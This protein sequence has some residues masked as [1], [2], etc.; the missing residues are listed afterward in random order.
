ML[1]TGGEILF[2]LS[3][4]NFKTLSQMKSTNQ[5]I[6][7]NYFVLLISLLS[8]FLSGCGEDPVKENVPELITKVTLTFKP[9]GGGSNVVV[10]A[11]DPDGEGVQDIEPDG[12]I[13]LEKSKSYGLD[14]ALVNELANPNDPEYS[15]TEEV[16]E[17]GDEHMF[18]FAWTNNLFAVPSGDGNIDNRAHEVNYQ[19]SDG[20]NPIGL[21]TQWQTVSNAGVGTFRLVL[22]HQ[23]GLKSATSSSNDGET[24]VDLTFDLQIQ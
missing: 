14:I 5:T 9:V 2:F 1:M 23:P 7:I 10:S 3:N 22:K 15:I 21:L 18:F 17:E 16:E 20:A 13:I 19:D 6:S 11:T 12:A 8:I 24:D 4:I